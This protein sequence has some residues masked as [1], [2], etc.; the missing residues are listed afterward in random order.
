METAFH[1]EISGVL[2]SHV[3]P[4]VKWKKVESIL[5]GCGMAWA[6]EVSPNLLLIHPCN[7]G[8]VDSKGS[9][10]C[11]SKPSLASELCSL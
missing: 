4:L 7:R 3:G 9:V 10:I 8:G 6:Q 1:K 2:E 5:L 11:S